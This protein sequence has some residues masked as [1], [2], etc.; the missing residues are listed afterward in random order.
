VDAR[1]P[2]AVGGFCVFLPEHGGVPPATCPARPLRVFCKPERTARAEPMRGAVRSA[3]PWESL[4]AEVSL[5][6]S[7]SSIRSSHDQINVPDPRRRPAGTRNAL[8]CHSPR[9]PA[10]PRLR[11]P[12]RGDG[13]PGNV[14]LPRCP[15]AGSAST[16]RRP[17]RSYPLVSRSRPRAPSRRRMDRRPAGRFRCA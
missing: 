12:C 16:G 1:V 6:E 5:G 4:R 17:P 7:K 9:R 11:R 8:S 14:L 15:A 13:R 10:S 2:V 3:A